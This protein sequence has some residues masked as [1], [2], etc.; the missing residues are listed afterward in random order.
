MKV[1]SEDGMS[2]QST[3]SAARWEEVETA[4]ADNS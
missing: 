2:N 4:K 1:F 3:V